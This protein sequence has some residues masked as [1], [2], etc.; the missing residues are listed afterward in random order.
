MTPSTQRALV[1]A[2]RECRTYLGTQATSNWHNTDKR[3]NRAEIVL[4]SVNGAL[5]RAEK[6]MG[7]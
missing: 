1:E 2:L 6:E 3:P 4:H 7:S 5:A